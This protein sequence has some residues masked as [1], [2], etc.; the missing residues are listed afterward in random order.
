[1]ETV[2][3]LIKKLHNEDYFTVKNSVEL[4]KLLNK[5]LMGKLNPVEVTRKENLIEKYE[6][7]KKK[8]GVK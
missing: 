4:N 5:E 7:Y 2:S 6:L 1:M 3:V 8:G